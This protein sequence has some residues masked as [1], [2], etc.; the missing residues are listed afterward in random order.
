MGS[1]ICALTF[2]GFLF[3]VGSGVKLAKKCGKTPVIRPGSTGIEFCFGR[4][5]GPSLGIGY[6]P[7]MHYLCIALQ[8]S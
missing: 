1:L 7:G 4:L 5:G 2:N 6:D 3:G 8:A